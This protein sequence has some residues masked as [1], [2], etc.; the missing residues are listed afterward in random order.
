MH[1]DEE[2]NTKVP[3]RRP[4]KI[5]KKIPPFSERNW[6]TE[7]ETAQE[8]GMGYST[9]RKY[10]YEDQLREAEG[11]PC[12]G[13]APRCYHVKKRI[14]YKKSEAAKWIERNTSPDPGPRSAR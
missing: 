3:G 6:M 7:P 9:L 8:I 1:R 5:P 4:K 12:I 2:G 14:Y 11:L 13:H 10:R